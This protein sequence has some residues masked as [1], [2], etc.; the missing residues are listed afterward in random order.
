MRIWHSMGSEHSMNLV[1]IGRFSNAGDAETV[2]GIIAKLI[3]TVTAEDAN[4]NIE[5]GG[6]T[7]RFSD[8]MFTT[9]T[10]LGLYTIGLQELEQFAYEVD[11]ARSGNSVVIKTD[12]V[13]VLAYLKVLLD[14]GARVEVFSAHEH[15]MPEDLGD[16]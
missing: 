16:S 12:E 3:D 4:G 10:E 14:K 8:D 15:E 11:V 6:T 13:D 7:S 1:M 2:R 9:L 5:V